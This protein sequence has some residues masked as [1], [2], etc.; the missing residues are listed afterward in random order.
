MTQAKAAGC[1]FSFHSLT[2]TVNFLQ[3]NITA[4]GAAAS[5][6][7]FVLGDVLLSNAPAMR[8]AQCMHGR[9]GRSAQTKKGMRSSLCGK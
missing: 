2:A 8:C 4:T 7:G 3:T 6:H 1:D 5:L 9:T